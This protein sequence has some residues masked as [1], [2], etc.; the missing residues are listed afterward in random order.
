MK[1]L[2]L[3]AASVYLAIA[4]GTITWLWRESSQPADDEPEPEPEPHGPRNC[5]ACMWA[6]VVEVIGTDDFRQWETEP[7]RERAR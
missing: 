5:D 3:L 2:T 7:T 4:A 1:A 6:G